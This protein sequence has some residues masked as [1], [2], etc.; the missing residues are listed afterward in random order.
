MTVLLHEVHFAIHSETRRQE[1][2]NHS[3]N[4]APAPSSAHPNRA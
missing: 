3:H 2:N 1:L 4:R